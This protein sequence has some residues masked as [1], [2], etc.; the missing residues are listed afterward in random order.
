MSER[1][2]HLHICITCRAGRELE[3]GDVPPGQHLHDAV[4]GL[5]DE[6]GPVPGAAAVA[7]SRAASAAAAAAISAPGKWGYLLGGL[8]DAVAPDLLTYGRLCRL[9]DRHRHAVQTPASLLSLR[10]RPLS[11]PDTG[12][13]RYDRKNSPRPIVTGFLG[14]RK[15]HAGPPPARASGR[16]A[17]RRDRQ[18]IRRARNRRRG[19]TRLRHRGLHRGRHRRAVERLPV[20]HGRRGLPADACRR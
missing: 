12:A 14:R 16:A 18:R 2:P 10:A 3:E 11:T 1:V 9:D 20:L 7:A 13:G 4:S 8:S 15:D 5:L 19:A 17:D 6:R